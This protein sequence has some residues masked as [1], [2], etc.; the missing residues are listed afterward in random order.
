MK[1]LP[2]LGTHADASLSD[3]DLQRVQVSLS[4]LHPTDPFAVGPAIRYCSPLPPSLNADGTDRV[5]TGADFVEYLST[6]NTR[7]PAGAEIPLRRRD[8]RRHA[9]DRSQGAHVSDSSSEKWLSR[10]KPSE[11]RRHARQVRATVAGN[12]IRSARHLS[13]VLANGTAWNPLGLALV[14][15]G[16]DDRGYWK[17]YT[18]SSDPSQNPTCWDPNAQKYYD[19][20]NASNRY[21]YPNPVFAGVDI[22]YSILPIFRS[23]TSLRALVLAWQTNG[24][25]A[26]G[27]KEAGLSLRFTVDG[28]VAHQ[29]GPDCAGVWAAP[30]GVIAFEYSFKTRIRI[31]NTRVKQLRVWLCCLQCSD[32]TP[33]YVSLLNVSDGLAAQG[34]ND[35]MPSPHAIL[36]IPLSKQMNAAGVSTLQERLCKAVWIVLDE[37]CN[38]RVWSRLSRGQSSAYE[39]TMTFLAVSNSRIARLSFLVALDLKRDD[40]RAQFPQIDFS[41]GSPLCTVH[42]PGPLPKATRDMLV[43]CVSHYDCIDGQFCSTGSLHSAA[44]GFLGG[45]GPGPSNLACDLCRF[46]ISDSRDPNDRYCPRDKCGS[47]A[48]SYPDCIDASELFKNFTCKNTYILNTSR[49]PQTQ[50]P[51]DPPIL[52]PISN[53]NSTVR[54]ARFLS[55]YNQLVG[56]VVIIQQRTVAE[57]SIQ[58]DS[59]GSYVSH[60]LP[61][62][63][64]VCQG[65]QLSDE[66]YGVDPTFT[67]SSTLYKGY[68][69]QSQ[70][71]NSMECNDAGIPFGFFPHS[72]DG[73]VHGPKDAQYV[74]RDEASSFMVYFTERLSSAH[75][76]NFIQYL[77]DGGFL[78]YQT[79]SIKVNI[80]TL[81]LNLNI[82]AIF[83]FIFTWEVPYLFNL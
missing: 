80:P 15:V 63:G 19:S 83:T 65:S 31:W 28:N 21:G 45:G 64:P 39:L 53:P 25:A 60:K 66:P 52:I 13:E 78:D 46:C 54:K 51:S 29:N 12:L 48:G 50:K 40:A 59:I 49:I 16:V 67:R 26:P 37:R 74:V 71:Y 10:Q 42:A 55:P 75:A 72:F 70:F 62:L 24:G 69:D 35:L 3:E 58:N 7:C 73:N 23:D 1:I 57:C 33:T 4:L 38:S 8:R 36:R 43:G 22:Q 32:H 34:L 56:A 11:S 14:D 6:S 18:G 76:Q 17:C 9:E 20:F 79:Q 47:L 68:V 81:N 30:E 41:S 2:L 61:I 77:R 44:Q 82:F 5:T 27:L